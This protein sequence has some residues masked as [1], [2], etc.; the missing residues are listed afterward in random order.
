MR[1]T[2]CATLPPV[3]RSS[4]GSALQMSAACL[5]SPTEP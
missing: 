5:Q 3:Q 2:A 4:K 1:D